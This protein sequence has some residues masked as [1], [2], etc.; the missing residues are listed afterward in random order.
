[1]ID[2]LLASL[3][4]IDPAPAKPLDP[5]EDPNPAVTA[6]FTHFAEHAA[7]YRSLLGP[8][9]S[10]RVM[11]HIRLRTT[12]AARLSPLLPATDDTPDRGAADPADGSRDVPNM[13][14][15]HSSTLAS[16]RVAQQARRNVANTDNRVWSLYGARGCHRPGEE[17]FFSH[18]HLHGGPGP[19]RRFLPELIDLI[20]N[21]RIDPG[22]VFDLE[23]PLDEAAAG[24]E[25]M[26]ERRAIKVLLHP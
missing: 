11:E 13:G 15:E 4:T 7:L 24:Y 19:V 8:T 2:D 1:M 9:G 26:D 17:L 22:K 12:A 18:V 23:L 6:F 25:A 14:G 10:A 3:T 20:W 21:R 5:R 16:G